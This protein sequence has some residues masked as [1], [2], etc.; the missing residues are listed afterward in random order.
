MATEPTNAVLSEQLSQLRKDFS[1]HK[2]TNREEM[3][4]LERDLESTRRVTNEL[5]ITM[6]YVKDAV[7]EMKEMMN[8]FIGVSNQQNERIDKF[9]NSDSRRSHKRQFVVSVLQVAAGIL[10][11]L[12]GI[13]GSGKI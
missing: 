11:A 8:S 5:N 13:W 1:D 10:I 7:S 4:E 3:K 9:I 2:K 12:I 6:N